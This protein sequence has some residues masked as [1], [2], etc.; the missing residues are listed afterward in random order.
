MFPLD[1][2]YEIPRNVCTLEKNIFVQNMDM[3]VVY[4]GIGQ[5]FNKTSPSLCNRP[6][7][8]RGESSIVNRQGQR[9][10]LFTITRPGV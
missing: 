4:N 9:R 2:K 8:S 1:T 6:Q 3:G 7:F 10:C 5:F